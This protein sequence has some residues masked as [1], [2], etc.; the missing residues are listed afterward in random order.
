[1]YRL[2]EEG[3]TSFDEIRTGYVVAA[4]QFSDVRI[5]KKDIQDGALK[6]LLLSMIEARIIASSGIAHTWSFSSLIEERIKEIA[7]KDFE[8]RQSLNNLLSMYSRFWNMTAVDIELTS[9][10]VL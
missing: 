6:R 9:Y 10:I 3:A 4:Q 2:I 7:F 5:P 1:M 8:R